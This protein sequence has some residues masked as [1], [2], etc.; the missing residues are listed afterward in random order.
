MTWQKEN[1]KLCLE[2]INNNHKKFDCKRRQIGY[3]YMDYEILSD[4]PVI[5]KISKFLDQKSINKIK[6]YY[7]KSEYF[8]IIKLFTK[9]LLLVFKFLSFFY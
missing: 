4:I 2:S 5:L 9:N 1:V 6:E 7:E 3:E 8:F